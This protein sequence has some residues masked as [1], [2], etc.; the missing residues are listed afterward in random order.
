MNRKE[1]ISRLR[2]CFMAVPTLFERD[3]SLNL[4]GLRQ[5]VG[6]MIDNGLREGNGTVLV[7]GATGEFPV[8]SFAERRQTAEAVVSAAN[9]RIAVIV[10]AQALGT[11]DAVGVARHASEIGATAIQV[12]P[13]FYYGHTDDDV[14][15]HVKM[16]AEAAP[17][18]G[19]V[20]YPTSWL[21]CHI[22][23]DLLE[24]LAAIPQVAAVKWSAPRP[25]EYQLGM[26]RF[27]SRLGMIDNNLLP[28]LNSMLGGSGANLH[29]AM[30]WPEWG[31]RVWALLEAEEW[32]AAQA[33]TNRVL[34]P[35]YEIYGQ[36]TAVT[37]GEGHVDKLALE[38]VG[39]PGGHNRPPTRPL[40]PLIKDRMR[41]FCTEVGVPLDRV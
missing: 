26:R 24:R 36:A 16:I 21:G 28:V 41:E 37:G 23:L 7:N 14:F 32:G 30:F 9:G 3:F 4:D 5:V 33:E 31:A 40:P 34:L 35:F 29:P 17:D 15:E 6:F 27:S 19:I 39:L 2:G 18:V 13:P 20:V 25:L 8:L 10:G 1:T 12:S 11:L 38:L 22:G